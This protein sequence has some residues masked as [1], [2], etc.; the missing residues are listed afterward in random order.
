MSEMKIII[1]VEIETNHPIFGA[2]V[3]QRFIL[4][5][6]ELKNLRENKLNIDIFELRRVIYNK[7]YKRSMLENYFKEKFNKN[8]SICDFNVFLSLLEKNNK[9]DKFEINKLKELFNLYLSEV[10]KFLVDFDLLY[11]AFWFL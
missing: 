4:S 9:L 7:D 3:D 11:L 6:Q 1:P 8:N 5:Y 2:E 10:V